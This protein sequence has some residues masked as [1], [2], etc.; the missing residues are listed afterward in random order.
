MTKPLLLSFILSLSLHAM[1]LDETI[2]KALENNNKLKTIKLQVEQS[3]EAKNAKKAQNYGKVNLIASYDHYNN[4][5]TL[6]PLTPMDIVSSADGAYKIPAT[7][8]MITTGIS[9]NVVLFNGFAQQNSYE[10]SDI[11]HKSSII[12]EKLGKEELIYNVRTLYISL[13]ALKQQLKAQKEFTLSQKNLYLQIDAAYKV[14]KKSYLDTLKAKNSYQTSVYFEKKIRSNIDTLK[15]TLSSLIGGEEFDDTVEIP[16]DLDTKIQKDININSLQ[17]Y[18]IATLQT[19]SAS[20]KLKTQ[21][22]SYYPVIDFSSYYGYNYGPNTTTNTRPATGVTYIEKGDFN[23][24]DIWQ[25]GVHLK[26]NIFDFG[27]RSSLVEKEKLSV[28]ESKLQ[29]Q[30]VKLELTK[31]L[32]IAQSKLK[33]AKASY[34]SAHSEYELLKEIAKVEKVKYENDASTITDLLDAQAKEKV[35][36]AKMINSKYEY[37]K[38]KYYIDYLLERGEN[39]K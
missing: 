25:V 27:V 23:S 32:K 38:A 1:S 37:Q 35:A 15:A 3:K 14:G 7:K 10:I 19:Q 39:N 5:R 9:Y 4:A 26:W 18:K 34:T 33:L 12:K 36:F 2:Q 30:D 31:N 11:L 8:D 22:A 21:E 28:L 29:T 20:K 24:K 13:L 17:R 6:A 16:I